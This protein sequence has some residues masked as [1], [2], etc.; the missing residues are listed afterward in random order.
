MTDVMSRSLFSDVFAHDTGDTKRT[1]AAREPFGSGASRRGWGLRAPR[2]HA[3][4]TR[5]LSVVRNLFAM[6]AADLT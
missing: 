4:L 3:A 6:T 1:R 2:P 5:G